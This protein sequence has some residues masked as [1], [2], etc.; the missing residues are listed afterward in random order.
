MIVDYG[1]SFNI[2]STNINKYEFND[3]ERLKNSFDLILIKMNKQSNDIK[4]IQ[5]IL[6]DKIPI[7]D[8]IKKNFHDFTKNNNYDPNYIETFTFNF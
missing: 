3:I 8:I 5:Q 6:E 1:F 4:K 2:T 7:L